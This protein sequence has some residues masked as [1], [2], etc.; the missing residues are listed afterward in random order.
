MGDWGG[1]LSGP[2]SKYAPGYAESDCVRPERPR[3]GDGFWGGG[4]EFP[5]HPLEGL[6]SG[7]REKNEFG[8]FWDLKIASKQCDIIKCANETL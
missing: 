5:P 6:G 7:L 2:P 1:G 4:S 3:A 8:A